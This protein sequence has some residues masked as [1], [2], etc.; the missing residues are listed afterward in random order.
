MVLKRTKCVFAHCGDHFRWRT[1]LSE[2]DQPGARPHAANPPQQL[3]IFLAGCFLACKDE[4]EMSSLS[5]RQCGLVV[6]C[7]PH[8]AHQ[9][10]KNVDQHRADFRVSVNEKSFFRARRLACNVR[11]GSHDSSWIADS[12][13]GTRLNVV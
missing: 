3:H 10:I 12:L 8:A 13:T 4:I 2:N 5:K 6:R 7:M 1:F 9:W 11:R